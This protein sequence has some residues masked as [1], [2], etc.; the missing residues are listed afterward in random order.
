LRFG[1]IFSDVSTIS[2]F[3]SLTSLI[4]PFHSPVFYQD[5]KYVIICIVLN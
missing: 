3:R 4:K 2:A 1:V 5:N